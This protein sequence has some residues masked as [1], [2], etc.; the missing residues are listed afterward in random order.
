[1]IIK[2]IASFGRRETQINGEKKEGKGGR[3]GGGRR[4]RDISL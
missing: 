3:G 4:A 1:V 2:N